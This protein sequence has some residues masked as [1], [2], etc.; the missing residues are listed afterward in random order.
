MHTYTE[1]CTC[2]EV[3]DRIPL[4]LGKNQIVGIVE[5]TP[6][7]GLVVAPR[8]GRDIVTGQWRFT[9]QWGLFHVASGCEV[10]SGPTG[11]AP[12]H[13]RDAAVFLGKY[14]IDWTLPTAELCDQYGFWET[15][16]AVATELAMAVHEG[17]PLCPKES[18]WRCCK[19]AWQVVLR[20]IHGDEVEVYTDLTYAEA[21]DVAVE[22]GMAHGLHDPSQPRGVVV[23]VTVERGAD[24]E[25]ELICA[26]PACPEVLAYDDP[27][28]PV[29]LA[30]RAVLEEMATADEWRQ[31]DARR[32]LCPY[33]H[34]LYQQG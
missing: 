9:G 10:F 31:I 26:H 20:D 21:E 23:E 29:R 12:G 7:P 5:P 34:P 16:R 4:Q 11:G 1:P 13:V 17:R 14:G 3:P 24:S 33:C 28:G 18:S 8:V 2:P 32:W 25:W 6:V 22:L 30:D 27:I 15:V 19:P